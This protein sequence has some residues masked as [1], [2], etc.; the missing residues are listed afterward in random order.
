MLGTTREENDL[1]YDSE[2][3]G[4]AHSSSELSRNKK[5]AISSSEYLKGAIRSKKR[6]D[7][8]RM[9]QQVLTNIREGGNEKT[10]E[11]GRGRQVA[12]KG[13][14]GEVK[15]KGRWRKFRREVQTIKEKTEAQN[16]QG[17]DL[18]S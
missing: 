13:D 14:G 17:K 7:V 5:V 2:E 10:V 16:R 1:E 4:S 18:M 3:G 6:H 9:E 8:R 12:S 15:G 11:R